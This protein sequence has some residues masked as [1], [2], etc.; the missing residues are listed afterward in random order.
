MFR[1]DGSSVGGTTLV[2]AVAI[3][4]AAL[5]WHR[6]APA[7]SPDVM[8]PVA[9]MTL[10]VTHQ[11]PRTAVLAGGCFWGMEL[12]FAHIEGVL[13]VVS[14]YAGG[15]AATADYRTVSSGAT[16]HAESVRIA[17]NPARISYTQLL[18][19]YFSVAHDPTQVN[20]QGYD[21][22]SQ[23]RSEIFAV[24]PAQAR[25][26]RAYI[27]QIEAAGVFADPIATEVS[28]LDG[29]YPA[30]AYHQNY[31]ARH[32]DSRYIQLVDMPKLRAL[33][34]TFERLYRARAARLPVTGSAD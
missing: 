6:E 14:G 27:H 21:I 10:P 34:H 18:R 29:F 16:R 9:T 1:I 15:S 8:V 11:S 32:P 13:D 17:Y 24:T 4:L 12:V 20:R 33:K 25:V 19:V 31:A 3:V 28:R 26:A 7:A 30:E 23:Y 2:V 22:G 5:A